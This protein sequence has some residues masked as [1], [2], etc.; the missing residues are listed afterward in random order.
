MPLVVRAAPA[1][2]SYFIGEI[3]VEIA[4]AARVERCSRLSIFD[5]DMSDDALAALLKPP[6]ASLH[7]SNCAGL[8]GRSLEALH[9]S[10]VEWS[11]EGC[12][13]A[14]HALL[15]PLQVLEHQILALRQNSDE[16]I[17][18]CYNFASP[19]NHMQTGPLPRFN[20]MIRRGFGLIL[21]SQRAYT[22]E[23]ISEP[24]D[25]AQPTNVS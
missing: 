20:N 3:R 6:L 10:R 24:E 15:S 19:A 16:G 18:R 23:M 7:L 17:E 4:L 12:F 22:R 25:Q 9:A 13:W 1:N 8:S 14:P 5:S 11:A 21:T 2:G